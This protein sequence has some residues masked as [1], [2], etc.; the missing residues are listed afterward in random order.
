MIYNLIT[1]KINSKEKLLA[2]LIDPDKCQGQ[3]LENLVNTLKQNPPHF[4][5]VG[6]SLISSPIKPLIENLKYELDTPVILYPGSPTHLCNNVDAILFLS[7]ISGRN[8]ELLIGNHVIAAPYIHRNQLEVISTGYILIDGGNYTSVE[9]ISQTKPI[10]ADKTDIAIATAMAGEMIGMKMIYMDAGSGAKQPISPLMIREVK[11]QL[12][13]PL[14]VGGGIS[15]PEL[16][17][18]AYDAGA[19]I[20]VVGNSVEKDP[21]LILDFIKETEL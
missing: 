6:G 20:V 19:D 18:D 13:I 16:L 3:N 12:Q 11:K 2:L 4:I 9:Y 14:M 15:S 1:D 21:Q 10:P 5:L 8:P 7:M 17:R